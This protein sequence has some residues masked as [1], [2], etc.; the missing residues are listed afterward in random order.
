MLCRSASPCH[1]LLGLVSSRKREPAAGNRQL[2]LQV[3]YSPFTLPDQIRALPACII[4]GAATP[5]MDMNPSYSPPPGCDSHLHA[6]STSSRSA[7]VTIPSRYA[8]L[9]L[10]YVLLDLTH[11]WLSRF[12]TR[13]IRRVNIRPRKA[14]MTNGGRLVMDLSQDFDVG[15]SRPIRMLITLSRSPAST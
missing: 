15:I 3:Q 9:A 5:I 8:C 6:I 13:R 2:L 12:E 10:H 1:I 14:T 4:P 11:I 7:L